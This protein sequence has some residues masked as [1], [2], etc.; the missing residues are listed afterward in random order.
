MPLTFGIPVGLVIAAVGAVLLFVT[1]SKKI[2]L[3]VIGFGA[4]IT[5]L[6]LILVVLAANSQM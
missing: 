6:T 3:A 4:L 2:A 1:K 5:L